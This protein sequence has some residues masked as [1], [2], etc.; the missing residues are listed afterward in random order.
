MIYVD[1]K[2]SWTAFWIMV[3]ITRSQLQPMIS[4]KFLGTIPTNHPW[5]QKLRWLW[6]ACAEW[7][8]NDRQVWTWL[9]KAPQRHQLPWSGGSSWNSFLRL[10]IKMWLHV[11]RE[12]R[13]PFLNKVLQMITGRQT[14]AFLAPFAF[15]LQISFTGAHFC[16]GVANWSWCCCWTKENP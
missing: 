9:R 11:P 5:R 6:N 10:L 12:I 3:A 14:V 7:L 13:F 4:P 16:G 15:K 2:P 8:K 1:S